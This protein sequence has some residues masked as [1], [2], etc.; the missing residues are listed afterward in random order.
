M[1]ITR[2]ASIHAD[3]GWRPFSFLKIETDEG[4]V[5][6]SEY[7]RGAWAPALPQMIDTLAARVIGQD[8][9]GFARLAAE[10]H[11]GAR[12]APGGLNAQAIAAI[13]NACVDL[14]AKAAGVPVAR[15]LGGPFRDRLPLY[16]SHC[17]SF[18]VRDSA[19]FERIL[20]RPRLETLDDMKALAAEAA[21]RGFGAAKTNPIAF[22]AD[23]AVLLNPGFVPG[24]DPGRA[25][26]AATIAA[27]TDQIAAFRDGGGP[28]LDIML[29]ANFG[30][31][32]EG[33]ARIGR[34]LAGH[35]LRWLE[36]DAH[37][38][39]ALA[40]LR[41]RLPMP[42]ASLET[43]YGRRG[44]QPYLAVRAADV[45][46]VD[47]A[48]NGIAESVRIAALAEIGEINVAPHNFYGPLADLMAAHFCAAVANFEIMEI[49]GDDV[50]WKYALLT[51]APT[52]AGGC[53]MLPDT[54]GWGADVNED[55]VAEHPWTGAR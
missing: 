19:Y 14:A 36:A 43:L 20:G 17:G 18:R 11:A 2:A 47:V 22:T 23:G 15:L 38:P 39:D 13:E 27:I 28:G 24:G 32:P 40:A 34:A 49:E 48:W 29:D 52:I 12:F 5:G 10:L 3:G 9:R 26:D 30:A 45:A 7:G 44:F 25:V 16:W 53:F 42:L 21:A 1:R 54:P 8:P 31:T 6:W 33:T 41:E 50:P 55:A 35:G 51:A 37:A 4:L 46:I